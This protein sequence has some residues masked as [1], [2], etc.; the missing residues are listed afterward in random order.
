M[1]PKITNKLEASLKYAE[2][3]TKRLIEIKKES[4]LIKENVFKI[5]NDLKFD[6]NYEHRGDIDSF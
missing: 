4:E 1:D 5:F 3:N 2:I 6:L